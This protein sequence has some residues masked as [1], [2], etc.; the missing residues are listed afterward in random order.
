MVIH[1]GIPLNKIY[2]SGWQGSR[3]RAA[4]R[5]EEEM[6]DSVPWEFR[7][8]RVHDLRQTFGRRLRAVEV[9]KET[10][11][12]LFGHKTGDITTHYS[13]GEIQELI[14]AVTKIA[15]QDSR[16]SPALI[17]LRPVSRQ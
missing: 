3:E 8:L 11:A 1:N 16:K 4:N 7:N 12:A 15:E 17:S 10:R 14:D 5:Y 6:K 13:G 9:M 2:N